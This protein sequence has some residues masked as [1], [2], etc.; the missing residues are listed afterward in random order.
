MKTFLATIRLYVLARLIR[1]HSRACA[2]CAA[3]SAKCD[4]MKYNEFCPT[5]LK[6]VQ[7][8]GR[9]LVPVPSNEESP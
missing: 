4:D 3:A 6:L 1:R 2:T 8:V 7:A 5:G 9:I